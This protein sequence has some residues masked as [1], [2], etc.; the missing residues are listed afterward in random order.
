MFKCWNITDLLHSIILAEMIYYSLQDTINDFFSECTTTQE[1]C[2]LVATEIIGESVQPV[3]LQGAFSYTVATQEHIVQFRV[4]ESPLDTE[5]LKL[6]RK[7]Y[8][9]VVPICDKRGV[10]GTP[11]SP[12]TIYVISK[13]PG[14]TYIE[15]PSATLTCFS[16]EENTI[17]DFSRYR[18]E[19]FILMKPC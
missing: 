17:S 2:N 19:N 12:L 14:I 4:A 5:R 16:W 1:E 18:A 15:V 7:I 9:D 10:V 13:I 8:G 3:Q 11:P 6:A